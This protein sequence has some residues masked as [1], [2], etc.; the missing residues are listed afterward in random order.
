MHFEKKG[1]GN[2]HLGGVD[3]WNTLYIYLWEIKFQT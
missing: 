2:I 1:K 3:V